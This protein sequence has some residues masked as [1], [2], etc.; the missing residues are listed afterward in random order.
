MFTLRHAKK[1]VLTTLASLALVSTAQAFTPQQGF[2]L[3][4]KQAPGRF[5]VLEEFDN[6]AVLDTKT[7]LIWEQSPSQDSSYWWIAAHKCLTSTTGGQFGWRLPTVSELS[8]L[9]DPNNY[10]RLPY[11]HPFKVET[12]VPYWTQTGLP[13]EPALAYA[14]EFG[15]YSPIDFQNKNNQLPRWCVRAPDVG[16]QFYAAAD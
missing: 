2:Q 5:E 3:D 7:G 13:D 1:M 11:D 10:N 4:L 8:S 6:E 15:D 12:G 16:S 14:I 9:L